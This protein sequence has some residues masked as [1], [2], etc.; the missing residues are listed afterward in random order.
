M[1]EAKKSNNV[2]QFAII[3]IGLYIG[4]NILFG[5]IFPTQEQTQQMPGPVLTAGS[6]FTIGTHPVLTLLNRPADSRSMGIEGWFQAKWCSMQRMVTGT[7][8]AHE[9]A[10]KAVVSTGT[11]LTLESRCPEP[12]VDVFAVENPG[13]SSEKIMP[14]NASG[15]TVAPCDPSVA[16]APGE[17]ADITMAPWKYS[18]FEKVGVYE[19]RIPGQTASG[20]NTTSSGAVAASVATVR[21]GVVEPN[22]FV[23][24]FRTFIS[25][26]FLNFLILIASV[27]PGHNLG[28][29]IIILTL[30]V[31]LVLFFPTQHALEGQKKMQ[32]LQPKL[33]AL[34]AKYRDDPKRIQEET[35]NLWKEHKIN[36]FQ[37]CLPMV[38]QFPILIGLFYVIRDG[39]DLD[40]SR[41]LIYSVYQNLP[42]HFGTAFL[43]LDLLKPNIVVMPLLLVALQFL[44]MKLTFSI[45]KRKNKKQEVIDVAA[46]GK[47]KDKE[48]SPQDPQQLVMLYG[49]PLMIGVFALQFPS[50]VAL[51][52]G[53][54]TLFAIGQ[55]MIVNRE[56][57]RV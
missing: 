45:Q 23:K 43:G 42:W 18:L 49:L 55:Q 10:T 6:S 13:T 56:H 41:H 40:L 15:A 25:A 44:Q 47:E 39:S 46:H 48:K 34:K 12:P 51:Y 20:V 57:L 35:M 7:P 17:S 26:P 8:S 38:V 53:I 31:K 5:K 29:A 28:I 27:T 24:A 50:A 33:N 1:P 9:C 19:A 36:P 30:A 37:S 4:I 52:W 16:L 21:F 22:V 54:S 11:S 3:F 32:M 2:L 14:L